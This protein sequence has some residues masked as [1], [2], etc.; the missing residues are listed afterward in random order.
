MPARQHGCLEASKCNW[1]AKNGGR[2]ALAAADGLGSG[3]AGGAQ[4]S[5][6]GAEAVR[7]A[8]KAARPPLKQRAIAAAD[9]LGSGQA[10]AESSQAGAEAAKC[11]LARADSERLE[12]IGFEH[13]H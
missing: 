8:L 13:W 11:Q 4:S 12:R 2:S 10:G 3:Q 5:Q 6:A 7:P 9:W 1:L